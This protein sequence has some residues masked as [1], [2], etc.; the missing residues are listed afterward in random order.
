ML[1][2][3]YYSLSPAMRLLVRK[4]YYWPVDIFS[5][6]NDLIPPRGLIYTGRGDFLKVGKYWAQKFINEGGLLPHHHI[7]DIGS[8]IG[9][10]AVGLTGYINGGKYE[11]FD[12]VAQ[13]V[14]WCTKNI[15]SRYRHFNF[16]YV[17]LNNDLY[18]STGLDAA[19]FHFPYNNSKFDFAISISVFTHML[20]NEVENYL[21]QSGRVLKSGGIL[22]ATFF[23]VDE[24]YTPESGGFHFHHDYGNY[25][26]MDDVVKSANVAF[27]KDYLFELCRSKG[28]EILSYVPGY[29]Q[30]SVPMVD[31]DFQDYLKLKNVGVGQTSS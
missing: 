8:G 16:T 25:L 21:A 27:R 17:D 11:G 23:I 18:K 26:L 30:K 3:L 24:F 7:L 14:E 9:R 5:S 31:N 1:R 13:G 12:A 10:M 6:K 29:W 20:D 4:I 28:F 15:Q 2:K 22:M 19:T